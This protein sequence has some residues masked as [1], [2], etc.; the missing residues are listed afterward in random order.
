MGATLN[1]P[2]AMYFVKSAILLGWPTTVFEDPFK[3]GSF[4]QPVTAFVETNNVILIWYSMAL[5]MLL[6]IVIFCLCRREWD[7]SITGKRFYCYK[8]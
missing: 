7:K 2:I 8:T 5:R 3:E 6:G 4:T 1:I